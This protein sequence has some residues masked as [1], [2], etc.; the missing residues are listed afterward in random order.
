MSL[1]IEVALL[2]GRSVV[3]AAEPDWTINRV[4]LLGLNSWNVMGL[5]RGYMGI[6]WYILG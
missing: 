5:Y 1:S 2:S 3:L 6:I 4:L